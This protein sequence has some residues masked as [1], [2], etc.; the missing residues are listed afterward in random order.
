MH[1]S[2]INQK[3]LYTI[4]S[5]TAINETSQAIQLC[6]WKGGL[7]ILDLDTQLNSILQ[8]KWIQRL[9]NPTNVFWKD[10]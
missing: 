6:I 3:R 4:S 7:G 2:K 9:L 8:T 10:L 1:Y 5:G